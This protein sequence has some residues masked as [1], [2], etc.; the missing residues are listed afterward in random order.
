[1]GLKLYIYI[2]L[3]KNDPQIGGYFVPI[4]YRVTTTNHEEGG[5]VNIIFWISKFKM[6]IR[7][8]RENRFTQNNRKI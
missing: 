1:M 8:S 7:R 4:C 6:N 3:L 2:C 5:A